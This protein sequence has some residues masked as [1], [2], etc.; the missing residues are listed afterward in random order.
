[1]RKQILALTVAVLGAMVFS[2]SVGAR[3]NDVWVDSYSRSDGTQVRG[4]YRSAPDN[5]F[6]NNWTTEGNVNPYTGESG[7][8]TRRSY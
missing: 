3:S 5:N 8:R 7:T 4:H 6:N 2:S 1:M